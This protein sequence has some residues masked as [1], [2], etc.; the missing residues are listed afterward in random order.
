MGRCVFVHT[1]VWESGLVYVG[2]WG[3]RAGMSMRTSLQMDGIQVGLSRECG[4]KGPGAEF[5]EN[6]ACVG[7]VSLGRDGRG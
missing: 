6:G 2:L 4:R 5:P 1:P 7:Q 3:S